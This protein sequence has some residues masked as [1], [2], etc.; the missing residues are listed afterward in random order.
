MLDMVP[1]TS[2]RVTR[3]VLKRTLSLYSTR[4]GTCRM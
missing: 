1:F 2:F 4:R 3:V